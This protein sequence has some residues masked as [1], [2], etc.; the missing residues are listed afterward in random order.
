MRFL[1]LFTT[2]IL[3]S[4]FACSQLEIKGSVFDENSEPVENASVFLNN[5]SYSTST[6]EDG[7]YSFQVPEGNYELVVYQYGYSTVLYPLSVDQP[8]EVKVN[9][10]PLSMELI[11]HEVS[12]YRDPEWYKN[13]DVFKRNFLGVSRNG[14]ACSLIN[15]TAMILDG[16]PNSNV[17]KGWANS[18]L[19][20][21]NK[22]LGYNIT[23]VL[24]AYEKNENLSSYAGYVTYRDIPGLTLKKKHLNAR[25]R[26]YKGSMMH[27]VRSLVAGNAEEEGFQIQKFYKENWEWVLVPVSFDEILSY[28]EDGVYLKG[29]GR[30]QL[31]YNKE[32]P[33]IAHG[34]KS[35]PTGTSII[36]YGQVSE[37][38]FLQEKVKLIASGAIEPPLGVMFSGY[39]GWEKVGDAV[40]LDY[41]PQ[42]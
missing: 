42:P 22:H 7:T 25:E 12:A 13:L 39:M 5:T 36:G 34:K 16:D 10:K 26:A 23:Y 1:I 31:T 6:L 9:L 3:Y 17:L 11:G 33:E 30:Y 18:P 27:F 14:K 29:S 38:E 20:I 35:N 19:I 41:Q 21:R 40:P 32:K 28:E 24:V 4:T 37:I 15:P 2:G 8:L